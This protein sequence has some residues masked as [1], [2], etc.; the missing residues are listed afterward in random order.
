MDD[1]PSLPFVI[2][3]TSKGPERSRLRIDRFEYSEATY[4]VN[5]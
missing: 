2:I 3:I 5:R 1:G 4:S